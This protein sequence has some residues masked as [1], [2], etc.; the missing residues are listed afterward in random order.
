MQ[1][2]LYVLA[3]GAAT[4]VHYVVLIALVEMA[5]FA[6][7]P[8]AI[9]GALCGALTGFMINHR[10]TFSGSKAR[11][12]RAMFRFMLTA[13]ASAALNGTLVWMSIHWLDWHYLLAQ[14]VA[15]VLLLLLTYPINRCWSFAE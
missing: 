2:V 7:T 3:G 1:F 4:L 11:L 15:T 6:A 9:I 12:Q 8:A 13:A 14:M 5:S 10:L